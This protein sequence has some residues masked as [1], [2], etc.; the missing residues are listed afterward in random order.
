M[1]RRALPEGR[2]CEIGLKPIFEVPVDTCGNSIRFEV[3]RTRPCKVGFATVFRSLSTTQGSQ[4][5]YGDLPAEN[6]APS[7]RSAECAFYGKVKLWIPKPRLPYSR[8]QQTMLGE[9]EESRFRELLLRESE[10][11]ILKHRRPGGAQFVKSV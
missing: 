3:K 4:R 10:L 11:D 1:S 2:L 8:F 7:F 9:R 5:V 6:R